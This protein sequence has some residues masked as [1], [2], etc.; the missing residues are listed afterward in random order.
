MSSI[1]PCEAAGII[2]DFVISL[3]SRR[4]LQRD[5]WFFI[6]NDVIPPSWTLIRVGTS[7]KLILDFQDGGLDQYTSEF[8]LKLTPALQ[9]TLQSAIGFYY[10]IKKNF[11]SVLVLELKILPFILAW[12]MATLCFLDIT[13]S[14]DSIMIPWF[15]DS[16][17]CSSY[18]RKQPTLDKKKKMTIQQW[19]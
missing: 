7:Q 8:P 10:L 15:H 14:F 11:S 13:C 2:F 6:G 4:I 17:L 12:L 3:Q 1:L 16:S 19:L 5:P 18:P 9:S